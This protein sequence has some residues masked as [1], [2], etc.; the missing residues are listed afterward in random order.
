MANGTFEPIARIAAEFARLPGIGQKSALRMAYH[1]AGLP[2]DEVRAFATAVFNG[3]KAIH[4]CVECGNFA[5][6]E[7]CS[8]CSDESRRNGQI[9]VVGTP[10]DVATM[11]RMRDYKGVYHVLGGT[12]SPMNGIGP[13]DIRLAE[14]MDRVRSGEYREVILATNPDIEGEATA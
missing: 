11:E 5:E 2:L 1:L 8:V 3:R 13:D 9:C 14:L 4:Y 6:G 10:R 12:L 7:K